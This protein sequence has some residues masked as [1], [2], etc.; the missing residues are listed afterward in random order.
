VF[1]AKTGDIA[2]WQ[3]GLFP[4]KW[5]KLG[6][7]IMPGTDSSY[8]W[9]AIIPQNEN[10]HI[11]NPERGFVSSANQIPVDSTY[12]YYI[13]GSYDL[14][15]SFIINR[16]LRQMNGITPDDM[17]RLQ[18]DNYNVFAEIARP[19]LLNNI[20]E[21]KLTQNEIKYLDIVR[22]WNLKNDPGEKAPTIFS[23]WFDSL[24]AQ[25]WTDELSQIKGPVDQPDE[26]T[27]IEGLLRDSIFKFVDNINTPQQETLQ[28]VVTTAFK[29]AVPVFVNVDERNALTWAKYK[30][31]R[32]RHLLRLTPLSHLQVNI[33]GGTHIINAAKQFHGPSWRMIVHLTDEI[34]AYGSYPG[35]QSGNP[36]SKYYD[37][38]VNDWAEGKYNTLWFMKKSEAADKRVIGKM[39]F[40]R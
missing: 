30:N 29:K 22:Q 13:G 11:K 20:N 19:V 2:I 33:G 26:P 16:Y 27:L 40:L 21:T 14:Y 6:D 5:E 17:Q 37:N 7:C 12:P 36:G 4:A 9:Q 18:T 39:N 8:L 1:A 34:E 10:P 38:F 35:G 15:R 31:T 24:E 28:D 3:Q 32:I 23:N 25:V